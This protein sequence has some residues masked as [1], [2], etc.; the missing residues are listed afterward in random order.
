MTLA[1]AAATATIVLI[2][3][4]HGTAGGHLP[5]HRPR[6]VDCTHTLWL[7]KRLTVRGAAPS[8]STCWH[9]SSRASSHCAATCSGRLPGRR[10]APARQV[11]LVSQSPAP[12]CLVLGTPVQRAAKRRPTCSGSSPAVGAPTQPRTMTTTPQTTAVAMTA[13]MQRRRDQV[14]AAT[15]VCAMLRQQVAWHEPRRLSRPTTGLMTSGVV[16]RALTTTM[17]AQQAATGGG[18]AV[19]RAAAARRGDGHHILILLAAGMVVMTAPTDAA[20]TMAAREA[21]RDERRRVAAMEH[22]ATAATTMTMMMMMMAAVGGGGRLA[23][24]AVI[25]V[26]AGGT[27]IVAQT[28]ATTLSSLPSLPRPAA[29]PTP[30]LIARMWLRRARALPSL[31]RPAPPVRRNGLPGPVVDRHCPP[32]S[33]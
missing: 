3:S 26:A 25:A 2:M 12:P 20:A 10:A 11:T 1:T 7:W 23:L 8:P 5:V 33:A 4:W 31:R 14:L 24:L 27:S 29:T 21:V 22:V 16:V 32:P 15:C 18:T 13:V 30:R 17:T 28:T 19:D 9:S 6:C